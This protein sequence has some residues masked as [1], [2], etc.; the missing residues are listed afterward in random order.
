MVVLASVLVLASC[1]VREEI[2]FNKDGSGSYEMGFDMSE[3]MKMGGNT[4]DSIPSKSVDTLVN[5][6]DFLD[7]KR[8]SIAKLPKKEQERLEVLRPLQFSMK[9]NEGEHTMDM[10]LIYEFKTVDDISKFAEAV[11]TANIK[12]ID[13]IMNTMDGDATEMPADS[14][15]KKNDMGALFSMSESFKTTF[16]NSGFTRK[17]TDKAK[18]AALKKKDTTLKADDPFVDVIRFKQVYRFPFRVKNI[19]NKNAKI[20]SDFKGVEIEANM[21]EMTNDPEFFNIEV[22]FEK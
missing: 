4:F 6:A 2:T 12:E 21:F 7:E 22:E 1:Q 16:S 13:D 19:N 17:I 3:L 20:L 15:Q 14:V 5:F 18:A 11:K 10:H 8:D 9:M